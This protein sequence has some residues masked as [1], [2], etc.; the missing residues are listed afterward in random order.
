MYNKQYVV[1]C[2]ENFIQSGLRCILMIVCLHLM[3]CSMLWLCIYQLSLILWCGWF[4]GLFTYSR[5]VVWW[6]C[7]LPE[8]CQNVHNKVARTYLIFH[9]H[10]LLN[11]KDMWYYIQGL[12]LIQRLFLSCAVIFMFF[13]SVETGWKPSPEDSRFVF[14]C[15]LFFSSCYLLLVVFPQQTQ[16]PR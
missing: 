2:L 10:T 11:G 9:F 7:L 6:Y 14:H 5:V 12:R 1:L 15:L 16:W 13:G 4:S 8:N 3:W